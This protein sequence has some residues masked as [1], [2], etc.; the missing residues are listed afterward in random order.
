ME[1]SFCSWATAADHVRA[2]HN[3]GY[4][5][6]IIT[7]H[8]KPSTFEFNKLNFF[9]KTLSWEKKVDFFQRGYLK[10]KEEGQKYGLDVFFGW[11]YTS[12]AQK[13]DFLTYGLE[14]SF[15]LRY[16]KDLLNMDIKDYSYLVRTN[17][18]Y[19]AQAHPYRKFANLGIGPVD[20]SLLDG[21]EIVNG[22]NVRDIGVN[23]KAKQYALKYRL[24]LQ[25]GSDAHWPEL[26]KGQVRTG[27]ILEKRADSIHDIINALKTRSAQVIEPPYDENFVDSSYEG[28]PVLVL[29]DCTWAEYVAKGLCNNLETNLGM[30]T[31]CKH[32]DDIRNFKKMEFDKKV[33]IIGHHKYTD[34]L[35]QS[36]GARKYN[37]C[38]MEYGYNNNVCA[39]RATKRVLEN[40]SASERVLFDD[41]YLQRFG[42]VM[43]YRAIREA[44]FQFMVYEFMKNGLEDFLAS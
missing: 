25:A 38:G 12:S 1:V 37:H 24:A 39:L 20:F 26:P 15:I 22:K 44:Q 4:T 7:D 31:E 30:E 10:A 36:T 21:L 28:V 18:G 27:I 6:I 17:G 23:D 8:L 16:G 32:T 11:E 29:Y 43:S 19:I 14:P 42:D 33:I 41:A 35:L 9:I 34:L 40:A 13:G 2:Y 5:G 3:A